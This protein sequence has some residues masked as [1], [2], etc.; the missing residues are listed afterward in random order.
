MVNDGSDCKRK[1]GHPYNQGPLMKHTCNRQQR[2]TVE[3]IK[4][5][6]CTNRSKMVSLY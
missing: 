1:N 4:S 5:I 3:Y 6:L 2:K